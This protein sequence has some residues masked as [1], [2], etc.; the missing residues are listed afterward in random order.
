[1]SIHRTMFP[2]KCS[3]Y[4]LCYSKHCSCFWGSDSC[5]VLVQKTL[6]ITIALIDSGNIYKPVGCSFCFLCPSEYSRY[7]HSRLDRPLTEYSPDVELDG[8]LKDLW[9]KGLPFNAKVK[10]MGWVFSEKKN[11]LPSPSK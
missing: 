1:M 7:L 10:I 11:V 8:R 5:K 3:F 6:Y 2:F 4:I 9:V